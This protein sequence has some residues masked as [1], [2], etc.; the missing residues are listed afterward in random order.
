MAL[1]ELTAR[2]GKRTF[3]HGIHPPERKS[4]T[5][6]LPIERMPFVNTYVLPLSQHLGA[7]SKPIVEV[8]ERVHRGQRIAD[9]AGFISTALHAPVT[10]TV[11]AIELRLHPSG[12]M[13]PA[14]VVERDPYSDQRIVGEP[15]VDP[16]TLEP[17]EVVKR[18]QLAGLVGLG[19]AAFPTHVK[20]SVP[21]G[22]R[23]RAIV[24]N[25]C[26]CEPYLTCDH[27]LMAEQAEDVV[28][29]TS[30]EMAQLGAER[31]YVGI[32][33]N[34]PDAIEAMKKACEGTKI[35]VVPLVVKYPQG[36]EKMLIDAA[37]SRK[38]PV[39][40][41]PLDVEIVVSNVATAAGLTDL[42][43]RGIPLVE[44][45]L[46]V[47]GPAIVKPR[48][49]VVPLGTPLSAVLDHCGGLTPQ[50]TQVVFGGPMMG[51][52]QKSLD[53]PTLKGTSGIL[54]LDRTSMITMREYACIRCGRC[55]EACPM[56]LNP[57]RLAQLV[58]YER[59][60]E[61]EGHHLL[62]CFECASCSFSCPSAIPLVQYLRIG[63]ALLRDHKAK[64]S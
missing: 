54:C 36:A 34:K 33:V 6:T 46:T 37:F 20:L 42:F 16:A 3:R 39:G 48:N 59:V 14:I 25:G 7:P 55:L 30:I 24:I 60:E 43:D 44:R 58:R 45:V 21:E 27:R 52:P 29:G 1:G 13:Q 18:V 31:G 12:Q 9:P 50:A 56:F 32:E 51:M 23:I 64:A 38:V 61:L 35:G 26:E 47:T 15:P 57:T 4:A 2:P 8:G 19:G 63:K 22:K 10:G 28:R 53:V 5:E 40:K 41:L 17:D 49:L 11:T 62:S